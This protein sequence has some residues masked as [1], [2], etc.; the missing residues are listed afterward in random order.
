MIELEYPDIRNAINT[1]YAIGGVPRYIGTCF[2]GEG[3]EEG[4]EHYTID[5]KLFHKECF[6]DYADEVF[7]LLTAREKAEM[8]GAEASHD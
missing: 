5:G 2:C 8:L 4:E 1:G 7:S 6:H 3:I